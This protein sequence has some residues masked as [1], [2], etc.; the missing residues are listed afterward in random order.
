[1][2]VLGAAGPSL[3]NCLTTGDPPGGSATPGGVI[4]SDSS[5][6][7]A[8]PGK[9]DH[10][11][12]RVGI[13]ARVRLYREGLVSLLGGA[14][15][16]DIVVV[17]DGASA[18]SIAALRAARTEIA[19]VDATGSDDARMLRRIA[20]DVPTAIVVALA[21]PELPEVVVACAE[22]GVAA[23]ATR[24]SSLEELVETVRRAARGEVV[25]G[26]QIGRALMERVHTLSNHSPHEQARARLTRREREVIEL[27]DFGLSNKQI[28]Q[29]LSIE[30]TTVK[31]HVH[32]ILAKLGVERRSEAAA[33]L[34]PNPA[35]HLGI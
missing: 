23:Y 8:A 33:S 11:S 12:V 30:L 9:T 24:D 7:A 14:D 31:N 21:I 17:V 13:C 1:M 27:I 4:L 32:S 34:R 29:R 28:A 19:L 6:R 2:D 16:I 22:A 5:R 20:E 3:D 10:G 35:D 26:P 25:C 15:G 18:S